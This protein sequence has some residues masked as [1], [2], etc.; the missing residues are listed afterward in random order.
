MIQL[1]VRMTIS[2]K[3]ESNLSCI[4]KNLKNVSHNNSAF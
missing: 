4:T 1:S 3:D 2:V